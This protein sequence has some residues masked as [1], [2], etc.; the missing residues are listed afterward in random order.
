MEDIAWTRVEVDP[1]RQ[2]ELAGWKRMPHGLEEL[3]LI[4][5]EPITRIYTGELP[6]APGVVFVKFYHL[7]GYDGFRTLGLAS[8]AERE[9]RNLRRVLAQGI[10]ATV[11]VAWGERRSL[12]RKPDCFIATAGIP[13]VTPAKHVLT[14]AAERGGPSELRRAKAR[15]LPAC[16]EAL[17]GIHRAGLL[18]N[19]SSL[20]NYLWERGNE[21]AIVCDLPYGFE[22]GGSCQGSWL[23][24]GDLVELVGAK[25][26]AGLFTRGDVFRTLSGYTGDRSTARRLYR[27]FRRWQWFWNRRALREIVLGVQRL[28]GRIRHS[29]GLEVRG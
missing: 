2:A 22:T 1:G 10:P 21:R 17:S 6:F 28:I 4:K 20:K 26:Y 14:E 24:L 19:R 16:G 12:G 11:P 29:K 5:D 3:R 25:R 15:V 9:W 18:H 8:R 7:R 27:R 23:A 13:D